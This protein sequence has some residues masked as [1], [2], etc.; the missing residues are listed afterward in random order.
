MTGQDLLNFIKANTGW[1]APHQ[2]E[3]QALKYFNET[4]DKGLYI[5][6]FHNGKL[7]GVVTYYRVAELTQAIVF[8]NLADLPPNPLV[9]PYVY[10]SFIVVKED[11]R[12]KGIVNELIERLKHIKPLPKAGYWVSPEGEWK[13]IER[14]GDMKS[15]CGIVAFDQIAGYLSGRSN[16]ISL[17]TLARIAQDNEFLLYPLKVK[18]ADLLDIPKPYILH[19][20]FHFQTIKSDNDL[21][22][23]NL[24]EEVYVLSSSMVGGTVVD[25]DEARKVRGAKKFFKQILA[26]IIDPVFSPFYTGQQDPFK[27]SLS[28]LTGGVGGFITGGV[29]GAIAGTA[30]TSLKNAADPTAKNAITFGNI[31]SSAGTGAA[32]G[33]ASGLLGAGLGAAGSA[34][35][36]T[37]LGGFGSTLSSLGAGLTGAASNSIASGILG[38]LSGAIGGGSGAA[39]G[40]TALTAPGSLSLN[41]AGSAMASPSNISWSGTAPIAGNLAKAAGPALATGSGGATG[42]LLSKLGVGGTLGALSLGGSLLSS[43]MGPKMQ[44]PGEVDQMSAL[45]NQI[46]SGNGSMT[47]AGTAAQNELTRG[48]NAGVNGIAPQS[49]DAF[50]Q[51]ALHRF[52]QAAQIKKQ[53]YLNNQ[54]MYGRV[55]SGE[56]QAQL[57]LYDREAQQQYSDFLAQIEEQNRKQNS[58]MMISYLDGALKGDQASMSQLTA[59]LGDVTTAKLAMQQYQAG[60]T[61]AQQ[62]T[63][64]NLG[65]TLIANQFNPTN[66]ILKNL[67]TR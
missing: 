57:E 66:Q 24:P 12:K 16:V 37:A 32:G 63:F 15:N 52:Q 6:K 39:G 17:S 44:L 25:D 50:A 3:E 18:R 45:A 11:Y 47:P 40:S 21:I 19:N 33:A 13:V 20:D 30:L 23:F 46:Q 29:P 4:V 54:A 8:D 49:S 55:N 35:G 43:F 26:P 51:A 56:T 65:T 38:K 58:D 5:T 14:G 9:G 31:L 48:I 27:Q 1:V 10:V 60:K 28:N 61:I 22:A 7:I 2:E 67:V 41:P 36:P 34:I 62:Q 64:G 59:L 53:E 42:G